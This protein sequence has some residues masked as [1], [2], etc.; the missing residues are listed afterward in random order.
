MKKNDL[1][2]V[3]AVALYSYL[4]YNQSAG[5]NFLLFNL[6]LILA[7]LIKNGVYKNLFNIPCWL[8]IAGSIL[9]SICILL[10]G[11][12]LSVIAAII[13]TSLV[14]AFS[15]ERSSSI[16]FAGIYSLYSYIASIA[17][18]FIDWV[19][20]QKR[21][22]Q[23]GQKKGLKIFLF[24]LP[25]L[26]SMVFFFLYRES[27]P[28]FKNFTASVNFDFITWSW[29]RFS[30]VGFILIYGF[31]YHRSIS[32]L[33]DKDLKAKN[34]LYSEN[35]ISTQN[36]LWGFKIEL[37]NEFTT[38][39]I[40][41]SL[42]NIL[43]FFVNI[44]DF[45]YLWLSH[46]LPEGL[47]FSES[48]HQGIGTLITSIVFAVLIILV[49]FRG[50]IN[51][52]TPNKTIKI[53]AYLWI[54]QNA[55]MILSTVMRNQL[56]I[57][58]YSLTYK[59]IGVYIYLLL[60]LIGLFTTLIKITAAKSNWY[61]FRSNGWLFYGVLIISCFLNWDRMISSFNL[62]NSKALDRDY[63]V[64]LSS[65]NT[66]QLLASPYMSIDSIGMNYETL[67]TLHIKTFNFLKFHQEK[68]WKCWN[69]EDEQVY[70]NILQTEQNGNLSSMVITGNQIASLAPIKEFTK[71]KQLDLSGNQFKDVKEL[72]FF[73]LMEELNLTGN[74][75]DSII[76]LPV[77]PKIRSLTLSNNRIKDFAAVHRAPQLEYLDISYNPLGNCNSLPILPKLQTLN[78]SGISIGNLSRLNNFPLL[79]TLKMNSCNEKLLETIPALTN[80]TEL[81]ITSMALSADD[82]K[83]LKAIGRLQNL[84]Q[85]NIASNDLH[86]LYT[87]EADVFEKRKEK[88]NF[89]D[90]EFNFPSSLEELNI[91]Y[92]KILSLE[93][94]EKLPNLTS[95]DFSGN[96][97]YDMTSIKYCEKLEN[98]NMSG[99]KINKLTEL[100]QLIHLT[101]L[102]LS[103]NGV[104]DLTDLRNLSQLR[105]LDISKNQ[106]SDISVLSGLSNLITLDISNNTNLSDISSIQKIKNLESLNITNCP[107]SGFSE[108]YRLKKLKILY[109][110]I[111]DKAVLDQL[112]I[113]LP[114]LEIVNYNYP[115]ES[116]SSHSY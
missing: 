36:M 20:K 19:E 84:K 11:N 70:K 110:T 58:E 79:H 68:E 80:L 54:L 62:N 14:A 6:F 106:L 77:V 111:S 29:V 69:I 51:F 66:D 64:R 95:L 75:I 99:N 32:L 25:V 90:L 60:C 5:I 15:V 28:L 88:K 8:A 50:S 10:Y 44:L 72:A 7:L 92:N 63:L 113:Q 73:P 37:S 31:F 67:K 52:Y 100:Q 57:N 46:S 40:L 12:T 38:G 41:F 115:S 2:L 101:S 47:N 49:Y 114:N 71:L 17:F 26:I 74:T 33:K 3:S 21:K 112:K 56:Y 103:D 76:S 24:I 65:A 87:I 86:N 35:F 48:V 102:Q 45:Q 43:L 22:E 16:L 105:Y 81:E 98:I 104:S 53:L 23:E 89:S 13:S 109:C 39:I 59:R 107:L 61:L 82:G 108:L 30:L 55:F 96:G 97:L 93:G 34:N 27:N 78:I 42:L 116:D 91:A 94:I 85:L 18:M 9:S 4:F 83:A 1:I